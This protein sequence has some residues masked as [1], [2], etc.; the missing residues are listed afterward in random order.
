MTGT[1]V[2]NA[3][4]RHPVL[5]PAD[6]TDQQLTTMVAA[7][8]DATEVELLTSHVEVF[9]YDLPAI[10]TGGRYLVSGTARADGARVQPYVFFV[11]VVHSWAR[12]PLSR[13]VPEELR[14]AVAPLVPWR[15][16]PDIYRSDL[17][18]R[19]PAGLTVPRAFAVYDLD[20]ESAAIWLELVATRTI[21]WDVERH[22]RAA[23]LLGRLAASA[24]VAP[25]AASAEPLRTPRLYTDMWLQLNVLP[26]LRSEQL[27]RL[28]LVAH[29]FDDDL[30]TRMLAAADALPALLDEL[31][32]MPI[33]TAHGDACTRNLLVTDADDGFTL[34]D[35][36]F[37]G[38]APIGFDLGQVLLGEIQMGER[39]A[40]ILAQ[41][42]DAC[43][44]AYVQGLRAEGSQATV[45]QVRRS[46]AILMT[47]FHGLPAIPFE[48]QDAAPTDTLRHMFHQRA[49][50]SRFIFDL[51][52][53]TP[54]P[55]GAVT[56]ADSSPE[57]TQ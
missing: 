17:R 29:A 4:P 1:A 23:Y 46:H 43:L 3:G 53:R 30:R 25:L 44:P 45:A 9:P 7:S 5:G 50:A 14:A 18:E 15:A 39:P 26:A 47:I 34:I 51:L 8:L 20:D 41:L 12:S 27:W 32:D 40:H 36:G 56:A 33:T 19:L 38:Q 55:G 31:D 11:K 6:I 35:F 52:D 16:E 28:P 24:S 22:E 42:E 10:N 21:V 2:D 57:A 54:R 13:H 49:A 37:W 48:H